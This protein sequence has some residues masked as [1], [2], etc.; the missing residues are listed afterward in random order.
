[1]DPRRRY[2]TEAGRLITALRPRC[3]MGAGRRVRAEPGTPVT[4]T[5]LPGTRKNTTSHTTMNLRR[6][7]RD[8][9]GRRTPKHLVTQ[10][11]RLHRSTPS[12]TLRH[13]EPLQCI[14]LSSI[15]H[16]RLRLLRAPTSPVQVLRATTRWRLHLSATRTHTPLPAITQHPPPWLI[17]PVPVQVLLATAP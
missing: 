12:T 2:T 7:R 16:M 1:M 6:R 4:P 13:P 14:T 5:H 9:E 17:R 11:C 10:K 3:M 8:T 15:L